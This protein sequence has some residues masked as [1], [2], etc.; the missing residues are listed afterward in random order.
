M[1]FAIEFSTGEKRD[2]DLIFAHLV[3]AM[4]PSGRATKP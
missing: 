4:C 3:E 2:Y 1:R